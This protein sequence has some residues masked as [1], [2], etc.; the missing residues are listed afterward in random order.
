MEKEKE[1]FPNKET[2]CIFYNV[3]IE[4][5]HAPLSK[6]I[7]RRTNEIKKIKSEFN[8]EIDQM[9]LSFEDNFMKKSVKYYKLFLNK[10]LSPQVSKP[11]KKKKKI[12]SSSLNS[13]IYF[14][15]FYN[16]SSS[17]YD[18][19]KD[20]KYDKIKK[21][22]SKSSN[23]WFIKDPKSIKYKKLPFHLYL[24]REDSLKIKDLLSFRNLS[25]ENNIRLRLNPLND[26]SNSNNNNLFTNVNSE[27]EEDEEFKKELKQKINKIK[28]NKY[29][30]FKGN[31]LE[32][33][34]TNNESSSLL[35]KKFST[36]N[37]S[38][39]S[40]ITPIMKNESSEYII[41]RN[42]KT[43]ENEKFSP[44]ISRYKNL[45]I[46]NKSYSDLSNIRNSNYS[47]LEKKNKSY[48]NL[49]N[50]TYNQNMFFN[51]K[52]EIFSN[53]MEN[54]N[55]VMKYRTPKK[56][57]RDLSILSNIKYKKKIKKISKLIKPFSEYKNDPKAIVQLLKDTK[58]DGKKKKSRNQFYYGLKNKLRLLS[59]VDNLKSMNGNAP[60]NIIKHLNKDYYEKSKK[61]IYNDALTKRIDQI[62]KSSNKGRKLNEKITKQ[63]NF[64]N[65][66]LSKN[67]RDEINLKNRIEKFNKVVEEIAQ[68]KDE[69]KNYRMLNWIN[70][71]KNN[72]KY[73][74][75]YK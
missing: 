58:N 12:T 63:S 48:S 28:N 73:T 23:F 9:F 45:E 31:N 75:Y 36:Q 3:E 53:I 74:Q 30:N 50:Q 24:S 14:G 42:I 44:N 13:K 69:V 62:Y 34:R 37:S 15:T 19:I 43:E 46:K 52:K 27:D 4:K 29:I 8:T 38:T 70:M 40:I 49:L 51:R 61:M 10:Y 22:L 17:Y 16:Q 32:N 72:K 11:K 67:K 66:F 59:I 39:N 47:N 5:V 35:L 54:L 6:E 7:T 21:I 68:E 60:E 20:L 55:K 25:T 1:I 41:P 64:I 26:N 56:D 57:I 18:E 2:A 65:R 71:N 33:R